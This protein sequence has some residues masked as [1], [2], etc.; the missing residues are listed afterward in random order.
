MAV[1]SQLR[2]PENGTATVGSICS[3]PVVD[4]TKRS[5]DSSCTLQYWIPH[6]LT[7]GH[8][9]QHVDGGSGDKFGGMDG[10]PGQAETTPTSSPTSATRC[11]ERPG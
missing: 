3:E 11:N 1:I 2:R 10:V 7:R 4:T 9:Q 6:V 8:N 5:G